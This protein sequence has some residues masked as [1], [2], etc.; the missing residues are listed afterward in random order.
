[1]EILDLGND[2]NRIRSVPIQVSIRVCRKSL[3]LKDLIQWTPG[4][5]LNFDEPATSPLVLFVGKQQAGVGQAVEVG[6]LFGLK[7]LQVK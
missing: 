7:L 4:T 5:V 2:P 1:M 6:S 3:K